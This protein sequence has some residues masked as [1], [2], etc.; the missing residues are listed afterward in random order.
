MPL[1]KPIILGDTSPGTAAKPLGMV[2]REGPAEAEGHPLTSVKS[3]RINFQDMVQLYG[4]SGFLGCPCT[5][6]PSILDKAEVWT[7]PAG[8]LAQRSGR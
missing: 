1:S 8:K 6:K 3:K 4:L 5:S 2:V 7:Q